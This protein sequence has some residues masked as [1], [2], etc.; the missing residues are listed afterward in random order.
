MGGAEMCVR[1]MSNQE[2]IANT[3]QKASFMR[4]MQISLAGT[5]GKDRSLRWKNIG[6]A[7]KYVR[8]WNY[9]KLRHIH[10]KT[11]QLTPNFRTY[12]DVM[13]VVHPHHPLGQFT[14]WLHRRV[15]AQCFPGAEGHVDGLVAADLRACFGYYEFT[16]CIIAHIQICMN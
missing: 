1:M 5:N 10:R 16:N 2:G 3:L 9:Q 6:F 12:L 4:A 8:H 15:C 11:L 7:F 13:Y 14:H